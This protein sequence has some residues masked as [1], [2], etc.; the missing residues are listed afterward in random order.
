MNYAQVMA[1]L[2]LIAQAEPQVIGFVKTLLESA[3]GKT[4]DEFLK[5]S[6]SIWATVKANALAEIAAKKPA[7]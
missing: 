7:V 3:V 6:D 5:E 4:G 2:A 1:L